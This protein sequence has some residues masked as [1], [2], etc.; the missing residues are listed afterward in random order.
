MHRAF[1]GAL[2][3]ACAIQ[4]PLTI[5]PCNWN[6]DTFRRE[7]SSSEM[8]GSILSYFIIFIRIRTTG[9]NIILCSYLLQSRLYT[10]T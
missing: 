4:K 6:S 8:R 3:S 7:I 5:T 2:L 9:T 10:M 1:C